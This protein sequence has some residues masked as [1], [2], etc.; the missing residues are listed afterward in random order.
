MENFE[1]SSVLFT[2]IVESG[3]GSFW[4]NCDSI[5]FFDLSSLSGKECVGAKFYGDDEYEQAVCGI[6]IMR[7]SENCWRITL[8][9]REAEFGTEFIA[10]VNATELGEMCFEKLS[11]KGQRELL[12]LKHNENGFGSKEVK[13]WSKL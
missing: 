5:S 3:I 1:N 8:N 9:V 11:R 13:V 12:I 2:T 10:L 4:P 6:V 7:K